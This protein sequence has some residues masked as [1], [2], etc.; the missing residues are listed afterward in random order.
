MK[1]KKEGEKKRRAKNSIREDK[2]MKKRHAL[3]LLYL[4]SNEQKTTRFNP[5]KNG[6]AQQSLS[7][8]S[9]KVERL[10]SEMLDDRI[11]S[12]EKASLEDRVESLELRIESVERIVRKSV[13]WFFN[14]PTDTYKIDIKS[15]AE[16]KQ[17][18]I[19]RFISEK[20]AMADE[21][22]GSLK[23]D[24]IGVFPNKEGVQCQ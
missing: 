2:Q 7:R 23:I 16:Q 21:E 3:F 24:W 1:K 4:Y 17:Q 10:Q 12:N 14:F 15:T 5:E 20:M 19:G 11:D 18:E 8:S 6:N 13:G 9:N 22:V